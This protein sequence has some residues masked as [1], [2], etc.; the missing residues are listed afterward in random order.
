MRLLT[1]FAVFALAGCG[2]DRKQTPPTTTAGGGSLSPDVSKA[3]L[4]KELSKLLIKELTEDA[5]LLEASAEL[6]DTAAKVMSSFDK[7]ANC[8]SDV[9]ISDQKVV[10]RIVSRFAKDTRLLFIE[11]VQTPPAKGVSAAAQV[12]SG[13]PSWAAKGSPKDMCLYL[14][15]TPDTGRVSLIMDELFESQGDMTVRFLLGAVGKGGEIESTSHVLENTFDE[16]EEEEEDN[17]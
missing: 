9:E 12:D 6:K 13:L 14:L 17:E 2:S 1:C 11:S 3:D 8:K 10:N 7:T 15:R 16:D 5:A 4:D